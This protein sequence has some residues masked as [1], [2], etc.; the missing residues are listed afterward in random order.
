MSKKAKVDEG[1]AMEGAANELQQLQN[2]VE[3]IEEQF[4]QKV[5]ELQSS[6]NK[7]K[8]P[9][10]IERNEVISKIP[11]FWFTAFQHH[12]EVHSFLGTEDESIFKHVTSLLV[13]EKENV[14]NG[15][16]ITMSFNSN[17]YFDNAELWKE[18]TFADNGEAEVTQSGVK[19]KPGKNPAEA[20]SKKGDK[21]R[22]REEQS[23]FSFFDEK[24]PEDED[25][26]GLIKDEMWPN[27]L[28]YYSG[29]VQFDDDD[30]DDLEEGFDEDEEEEL[31]GE[32]EEEADA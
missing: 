6:F 29:E 16:K 12:P 28:Q 5:L 23:F 8:R 22:A 26:A 19:W 17:D 31:E 13:D 11:N 30:D 24:Q 15:Y 27:P 32:E 14:K 21:K 4:D 7:Q 10:Y 20:A 9:I 3:E 18:I 1:A 25:L 2:K